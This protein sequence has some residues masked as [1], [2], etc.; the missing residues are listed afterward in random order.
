MSFI[1]RYAD[2]LASPVKIEEF[3]LAFLKVD[4]TS[5]EGLFGEFLNVLKSLKLDI[6]DL[7]GQGYDNSSNMKG[8]HKGVQKRVLESKDMAIDAAITHLKALISFFE[9][10][11]ESGFES[12]FLKH[13]TE[14]DI[15]GKELFYELILLTI[16]VTVASAE[17]SFLKLKLIKSY[18]RSTM[19]Q[20]RLNGLAMMSIE[21]DILKQ[22][23]CN[24]VAHSGQFGS[25]NDY[26]DVKVAGS[27][28]NLIDLDEVESP[29]TEE[30]LLAPLPRK[31]IMPQF[32]PYNGSRDLI[33]HL[34]S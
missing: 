25:H 31:F 22:I 13:N 9:N 18:L 5:E 14:F 17:R 30:I 33:E 32:S 26:Q 24:S 2:V 23:D 15:D 6:G 4:D 8:K 12:E 29:F 19:S 16:P 28:K 3:F 34:E 21:K 20:K 7:R 1:V 27:S 10:Y 11:R